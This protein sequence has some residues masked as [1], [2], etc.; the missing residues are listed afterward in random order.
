MLLLLL[1]AAAA[2]AE[3]K[4]AAGRRAKRSGGGGKGKEDLDSLRPETP[5]S[6]IEGRSR[7]IRKSR[8]ETRCSQ[9]HAGKCK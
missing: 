3:A 5:K 9:S 6:G 2:A 1:L 7:F 8:K 4:S